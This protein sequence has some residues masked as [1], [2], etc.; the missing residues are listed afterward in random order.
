MNYLKLSMCILFSCFLC[1]N[2]TISAQTK[3][4]K[5]RF[6]EGDNGIANQLIRFSYY[7]VKSSSWK[8]DNKKTDAQGFATFKVAVREDGNS[9]SFFYS[10]ED[11]ATFN[12][13]LAKAD[14]N[15]LRL[16]RI[17]EGNDLLE[18]WINKS[19]GGSN[20]V[21]SIQFWRKE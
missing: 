21:G 1:S 12:D 19:G 4:V 20:K 15:E 16:V 13:L 10:L 7:D 6:V 3:D 9:C 18:L 8:T 2:V 11:E 14:K 17:P 5:I